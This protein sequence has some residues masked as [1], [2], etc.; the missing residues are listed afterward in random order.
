MRSSPK[1]AR[2]VAIGIRSGHVALLVRTLHPQ[3]LGRRIQWRQG[4]GVTFGEASYGIFDTAAFSR[5]PGRGRLSRGRPLRFR[6]DS[7]KR[8][9]FRSSMNCAPSGTEYVAVPIKVSQ[10]RGACRAWATRHPGGFTDAH[11]AALETLIA[12]ARR[13]TENYAVAPHRDQS[14]RYLCRRGRPVRASWRAAS[15]RLQRDDPRR[16]LALGHSAGSPSWPDRISAADLIELLNR[17]FDCQIPAIAKHGGEVL[18]FIRRRP[19]GDLPR[20]PPLP[21]PRTSAGLR[22]PRRRRCG[23]PS[24]HC[25]TGRQPARATASR[26]IS[27]IALWQIRRRQPA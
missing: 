1:C 7:P 27:G 14:P 6:L 10:W 12:P 17:Y 15:A 24:P 20:W 8:A 3:I 22:S 11:R 5:Q 25:P 9:P 16:D 23:T 19:P 13:V 26:C 18:K 2:T 4:A 21:D